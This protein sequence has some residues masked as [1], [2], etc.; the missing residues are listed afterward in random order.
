MDGNVVIDVVRDECPL[1]AEEAADVEG[2]GGGSQGGDGGDPGNGY[3]HLY[4]VAP[5]IYDYI[6]AAA[7]GVRWGT[8][9]QNWSWFFLIG[10]F[11]QGRRAS[12]IWRRPVPGRRRRGGVR[13]R[14]RRQELRPLLHPDLP[15]R[16]RGAGQSGL[17]RRS[18]ISN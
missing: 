5:P 14:P 1:P 7:G 3:S 16:S 9:T 4:D 15:Q 6:P 2:G 18:E 12:K 11:Q 8:S 17:Q 13:R 10:F